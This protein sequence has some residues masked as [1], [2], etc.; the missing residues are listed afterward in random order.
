MRVEWIWIS[1]WGLSGSSGCCN[2]GSASSDMWG[3]EIQPTANALRRG[4]GRLPDDESRTA[5][6]LKLV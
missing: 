6:D 4:S 1:S 3:E 2:L 5:K